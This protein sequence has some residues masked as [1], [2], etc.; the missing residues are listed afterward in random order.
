MNNTNTLLQKFT[1]AC[2]HG[3]KIDRSVAV[4]K[5]RNLSTVTVHAAHAKIS[6]R[7]RRLSGVPNFTLTINELIIIGVS[8]ARFTGSNATGIY[9]GRKL[10]ENFFPKEITLPGFEPQTPWLRV[11]D[12]TPRTQ[13]PLFFKT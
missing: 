10:G 4:E 1:S 8:V 9:C 5:I 12:S 2:N 13:H 6:D 7:P 3:R 11:G